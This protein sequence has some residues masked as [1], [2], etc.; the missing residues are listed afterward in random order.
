M[1]ITNRKTNNLV[2]T[3][4]IDKKMEDIKQSLQTDL[5]S[6]PKQPELS[7]KPKRKEKKPSFLAT[8]WEE[9]KKVNWPTLQYTLGWSVTIILFTA[10]MSISLGFFDHVFTG[11]IKFVNCT[12]PQ[13][14]AKSIGECSQNF[15]KYITLQ[16]DK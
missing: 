7:T 8:T 4:L 13:N 3:Q 11:S 1:A 12:S 2:E 5:A 6:Q 9:V 10:I 14:E 15:L 16:S